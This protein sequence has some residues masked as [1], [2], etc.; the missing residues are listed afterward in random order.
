LVQY[1]F[2]I[3]GVDQRVARL[4]SDPFGIAPNTNRATLSALHTHQIGI[5]FNTKRALLH[6]TFL[7]TQ[8]D[9]RPSLAF[10]LYNFT[11][12]QLIFDIIMSEDEDSLPAGPPYIATHWKATLEFKFLKCRI[13][14]MMVA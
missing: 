8:N 5:C 3:S 2:G 9:D 12:L 1:Q 10:F 4:V 7:H 11:F 6:S 14:Q 13:S